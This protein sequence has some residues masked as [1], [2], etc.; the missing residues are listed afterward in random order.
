M[1]VLTPPE[2]DVELSAAEDKRI[3]IGGAVSGVAR[4]QAAEQHHFGQQKGPQPERDG[5][6]L[7]LGVLKLMR[8]RG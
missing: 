6:A 3:R 8:Q 5:L 1:A 7:L 2:H 4:E